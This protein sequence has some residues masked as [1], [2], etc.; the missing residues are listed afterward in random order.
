[1]GHGFP[2]S[3][4]VVNIIGSLAMGML[5]AWL[6]KASSGGDAIRHFMAIGLLGGFTTFSA[7]S[8]DVVTLFE[9]GETMQVMWYMVGSVTLSVL[10]L[11]V[12]MMLM[13]T[14]IV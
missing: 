4:M 9:R 14:L 2:Y 12:G 13:R 6:A 3:T 8:L 10:G 7:F 5:I 11:F 1:M